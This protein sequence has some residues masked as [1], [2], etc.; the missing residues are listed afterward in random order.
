MRI[1][2]LAEVATRLGCSRRTIER[3]INVGEGP[4]LTQISIRRIGVA[5]PD[6]EAWVVGRRRPAP[7]EKAA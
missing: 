4:T 1:L 6:F 7:G 3:A 2:T 5:E